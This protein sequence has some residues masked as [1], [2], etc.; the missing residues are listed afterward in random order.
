[1]FVFC[2]WRVSCV[3]C[4]VSCVVCR[5]SCVVCRVSCVVCRVVAQSQDRRVWDQ[6]G[7]TSAPPHISTELFLQKKNANVFFQFVVKSTKAKEDDNAAA[8]KEVLKYLISLPPIRLPLKVQ[9]LF[10]LK[11]ASTEPVPLLYTAHLICQVPYAR[12]TVQQ[13]L[14]PTDLVVHSIFTST[15][16][17]LLLPPDGPEPLLCFPLAQPSM[18]SRPPVD[19]PC[20]CIFCSRSVLSRR[21][22]LD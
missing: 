2:V 13:Y 4:R 16:N 5:V 9:S 6:A 7:E 20:K 1:M 18:C 19:H 10:M 22:R 11:P 17:P 14:I 3:V 21:R 12:T 8:G 15:L